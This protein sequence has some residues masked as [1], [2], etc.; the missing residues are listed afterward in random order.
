MFPLFNILATSH[1]NAH[2]VIQSNK[3]ANKVKV[4]ISTQG[5]SL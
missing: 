1:S 2:S 3:S 4:M 5:T